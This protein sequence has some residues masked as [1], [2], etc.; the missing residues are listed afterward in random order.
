[1]KLK[2]LLLSAG[3][4]FAAV[5]SSY[6]ETAGPRIDLRQYSGRAKAPGL[7]VRVQPMAYLDNLFC[8][9]QGK[10]Q[11][12]AFSFVDGVPGK[13]KKP[14]IFKVTVPKGFSLDLKYRYMRHI[15]SK[16]L[17]NG[18]VESTYEVKVPHYTA[19]ISDWG[20]AYGRI[21]TTL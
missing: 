15:S 13:A 14:L 1:M 9:L 19:N 12:I 4:V 8:V 20:C 6:G 10:E 7:S 5:F 18:S 2:H 17:K 21:S 11:P 16:T 3:L